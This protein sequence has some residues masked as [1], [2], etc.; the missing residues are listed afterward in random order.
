MKTI[1]FACTE[2][3]KRSQMAQ[4]IFNHYAK[5]RN[6]LAEAI[7]A[8]TIP[9]HAVDPH[10]ADILRSHHIPYTEHRPQ[11]LTDELLSKADYI[12]SFG[13]LIPDLF[14]KEKFEEWVVNDPR[15]TDEYED[16]FQTIERNVLSLQEHYL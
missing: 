14:P 7:S 10:V 2:N 13:C 1:L 9:A 8:G 4:A 11:K 15:T 12:I 3:K 5:Q 6:L 16:A